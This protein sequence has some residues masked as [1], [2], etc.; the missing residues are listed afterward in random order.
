MKPHLLLMSLCVCSLQLITALGEVWHPEHFVCASCNAE[1]GTRGFF[2]RDGR[3]YCEKD[4]QRLF[5]P[6]C[7]YCKGP[8]TQV[9]LL[10][11]IDA[12]HLITQELQKEHDELTPDFL[13]QPP[14]PPTKSFFCG[15]W[16][17]IL[18]ALDQSWHPE[19]F[20]CTHCG[21]RF[22]S[23]G[24]TVCISILVNISLL[25]YL[26]VLSCP[27]LGEIYWLE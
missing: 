4:Y 26:A 6:R 22:G 3:P 7:G 23:E 10:C 11:L 18:T 1:L 20:F 19:H 15:F 13:S 17:Q 5:S 24:Q 14:P 25:C 2:E 12:F 8:I 21:N 16:Q 27:A 9:P